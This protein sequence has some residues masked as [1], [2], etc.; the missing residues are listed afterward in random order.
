ML[1]FLAGL[2]LD[3]HSHVCLLRQ[4]Y[5]CKMQVAAD[6][7]DF[8]FVSED[9]RNS[10]VSCSSW[11]F[12]HK[13]FMWGREHRLVGSQILAFHLIQCDYSRYSFYLSPQEFDGLPY[14]AG[15]SC[16]PTYCS[17]P[18]GTCCSTRSA[19]SMG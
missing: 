2:W 18:E 14:C 1:S 7:L 11:E 17:E 9:L 16:F 3:R 6:G 12:G 15:C 13:A 4:Y 8:S 10:S 19:S 5:A